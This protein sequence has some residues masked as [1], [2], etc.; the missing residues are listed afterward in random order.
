MPLDETCRLAATL[1]AAGT[2]LHA[3][4]VEARDGSGTG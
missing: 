4:G 2:Q 3:T 1:D